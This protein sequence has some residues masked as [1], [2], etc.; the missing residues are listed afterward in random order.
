MWTRAKGGLTVPPADRLN[1]LVT[2]T[3][4]LSS[5]PKSYR[6]AL[7]DPNWLAAMQAEYHALVANKMWSLVPRPSTTNL[8][9]GKW[10][11]K[12]K[13]HSDDTL[14]RYKAHWVACGYSQQPSNDYDETF[15][16]VA[17]PAMI[18]TVLSITT[19]HSWSIRQHDV[20]NAFLNG[21]LDEIV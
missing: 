11:F 2:H 6:V 9:S 13:F 1:L 12:H 18:Q 8:V 16:L 10:V 7:E 15:S 19:S 17:K 5:I 3:A 21:A 14:S 20:R 4:T